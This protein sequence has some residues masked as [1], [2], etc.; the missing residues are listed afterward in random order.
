MQLIAIA[1]ICNYEGTIGI[2]LLDIDTHQIQDVPANN[3]IQVITAKQAYIEN[4][5]VKNGRLI[6]Y[7]GCIDDLPAIIDG[8]LCGPSPLIVIN[9]IGKVGYTVSDYNG[10]IVKL[11]NEEVIEYAKAQGISNGRL[12]EYADKTIICTIEGRYREVA[13][14]S[15]GED[16]KP[17]VEVKQ[18]SDRYTGEYIAEDGKILPVITCDPTNFRYREFRY[19]NGKLITNVYDNMLFNVSRGEIQK[20]IVYHT[21][22]YTLAGRV[23][24]DILIDE[25]RFSNEI[26]EALRMN[27][28]RNSIDTDIADIRAKRIS[29][30][31]NL[32]TDTKGKVDP[33]TGILLPIKSIPYHKQII[34][35]KMDTSMNAYESIS[36]QEID[37]YKKMLRVMKCDIYSETDFTSKRVALI[38][39][40]NNR[41]IEYKTLIF[42]E[43]GW[44]F[45]RNVELEE[46]YA[47]SEN[48]SN[49][50]VREQQIKIVGLDGAYS[51]D[52][53]K[54]Y[55]EYN[56][57]PIKSTRS[58]KASLVDPD[59][60]EW[61]NEKGDLK[62]LR[63]G[64]D[65]IIVPKSV[66]SILKKSI[67]VSTRNKAIIFGDNIEK[68]SSIAIDG[69]KNIINYIEIGCNKQAGIPLVK[70]LLGL[71]KWNNKVTVKFTRDVS[72]EEYV[73]LMDIHNVTVDS[74]IL[75]K[76]TDEFV[77][78]TLKIIIDSQLNNFNILKEPIKYEYFKLYDTATQT[79]KE[80]PYYREYT[81]F[82]SYYNTLKETW[83]NKLMKQSSDE[84]KSNIETLFNRVDM[85]IKS[86]DKEFEEATGEKISIQ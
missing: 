2:R 52:I 56:K 50:E 70:S 16:T 45:I 8:S 27:S 28:F 74:E 33:D 29:R 55:A 39:R 13:E 43:M 34:V 26:E 69:Y 49:V 9:Q 10:N 84:L 21:N 67:K 37:R 24:R 53:E 48:Y 14:E 15:I 73:M 85:Q 36:K 1:N 38:R 6:G 63:S 44:V 19:D 5:K 35:E 77:I 17:K 83:T 4:L 82:I 60:K 76:I 71:L 31:P 72:P 86:R 80:K 12:I 40:C 18:C 32:S 46:I 25:E 11:T 65:N 41:G 79:Y 23:Y 42:N 54:I 62:E 59:Y 68:A 78:N 58:L 66:K 61:I 81:E 3:I 57:R 22:K 30:S 7:N 75:S 20:D 64:T 47:N 51:Y